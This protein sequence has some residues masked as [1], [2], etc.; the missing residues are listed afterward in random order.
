MSDTPQ[1]LRMAVE[2]GVATLTLDNP[3]KR[4]A[5]DIPLREQLE[6]AVR[7]I[8]RDAW[9]IQAHASAYAEPDIVRP[10]SASA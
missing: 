6:E 3:S 2:A 1:L 5:L 8:R 4:N 7:A 10:S 9:W